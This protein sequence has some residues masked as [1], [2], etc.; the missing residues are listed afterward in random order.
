MWAPLYSRLW[1]HFSGPVRNEEPLESG[2]SP[3]F[4]A[5]PAIERQS[6]EDIEESKK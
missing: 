1:T 5:Y 4:T 2:Q 6:R 3:D